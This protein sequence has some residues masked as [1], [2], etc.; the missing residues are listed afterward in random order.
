[1]V[2]YILWLVVHCESVTCDIFDVWILI[3]LW[4]DIA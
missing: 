3:I 1:M 4:V 2:W